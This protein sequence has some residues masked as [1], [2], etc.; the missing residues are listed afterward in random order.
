MN[1]YYTVERNAQILIYLLKQHGVR[2]IVVSPG[3]TNMCFACSVQNDP[4]F[5]LYSSV[6]ERSA[7]YIACGMAAESGEPV[8]L[9]CTGATASRNYVPGLT[10]AYYR[11]LPILAIT[12]SQHLSRIGNNFPQMLDRTNPMNDIAKISVNIDGVS[13]QVEEWECSVKINRALIEL[14]R[15]GGGPVHINLVTGYNRDFS[16]KT[17]PPAKVIKHITLKDSFPKIDA[18]SVAI[19][20]GNHSVFSEEEIA[21]IDRFCELYN[22]FVICDQTSNYSGKYP[23]F[24][25][26]VFTQAQRESKDLNIDLMIYIGNVS[27]AFTRVRAGQV[28]R[29]NP[30]GEIRD[31]FK[32]QTY[33]FEM[34]EIDFFNRINESF[35]GNPSNMSNYKS[36]AAKYEEILAMVPELPFSNLWVAQQ[37]KDSLPENAVLHLGILNSLRAWNYFLPKKSIAAYSNTGGFG[38]DGNVSSLIGASIVSPQKLFFGV[39]GDLAFFYD[40]NSIGNRHVGCNIRLLVI[41]N[42]MGTEFTIYSSQYQLAGFGED[43]MPYMAAAGHFGNKSKDLLKHYATDLGYE[44]LSASSKE[45]FNVAL[46]RFVTPELTDKPMVFEVFTDQKDESEALYMLRHSKRKK[47]VL[48]LGGT[49]AMG[50]ELV[51]ALARMGMDVYVTSRSQHQDEANVKYIVGNAKDEEF[52]KRVLAE[53]HWDAVVDFMIYSTKE[54]AERSQMLLDSTEQYFFLSSARVY[55]AS[56][57]ALTEESPRLLDVCDDAEYLKTDE[58]ALS[59]ARQEDILLNSGRNNFTIVRPSLTYNYNRLQFTTGEKGDWLYR[60]LHD[61]SVIFPQDMTE[62]KAAMLSGSDVAK[63]MALLVGNAKAY[64]QVLQIASPVSMTWTEI[65]DTYQQVIE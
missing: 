12:S 19:Y 23:V 56:E 51:P 36:I 10:E 11:K 63:A 38:I 1:T 25:P 49:G 13:N 60:V 54:F 33:T 3:A 59:K 58:Y 48:V 18:E 15:N 35:E 30:D 2:K 44:Y 55:A 65:L 7:A 57:E 34:D 4:Y 50:V 39:V 62:I 29:V 46:E 6:D 5:Q 61:K 53:K 45:E 26:L 27:G 42:G 43:V 17:L 21:A 9:S 16:V 14:P 37:M 41:N 31:F 8:A 40:M 24:P 20:I 47:S 64:G 52:L 32:K 22:A 28:W